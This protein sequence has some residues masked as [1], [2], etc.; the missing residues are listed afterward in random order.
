MSLSKMS[1]EYFSGQTKS[2]LRL[3]WSIPLAISACG[4]KKPPIP[5]NVEAIARSCYETI[6][7][8]ERT[9]KLSPSEAMEDGKFLILWSIV[10]FPNEQGS[11]TVDGSGTVLLLT[12]NASQSDTGD[13]GDTGDETETP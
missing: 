10:E 7:T 9:P 2:W 3:L 11:C 4:P 1:V 8:Q 6:L 5:D 12:S 13:T